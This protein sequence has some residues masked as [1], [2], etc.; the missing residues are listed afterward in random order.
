MG[1]MAARL[2]PP[3][4]HLI[5]HIGARFHAPWPHAP[6]RS[7]RASSAGSMTDEFVQNSVV[8]TWERTDTSRC[9]SNHR[10]RA[11]LQRMTAAAAGAT[12]YRLSRFLTASSCL[13]S[14]PQTPPVGPRNL[15]R[16][17]C[18][19]RPSVAPCDSL[20]QAGECQRSPAKL[21]DQR[22]GPHT[23]ASR[24]TRTTYMTTYSCVVRMQ[25][26]SELCKR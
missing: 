3:A 2:R 22:R 4:R 18:T 23:T 5:S 15:K 8:A 7:L 20:L 16:P 11:R 21:A 9:N 17:N 19:P 24:G 10:L 25:P 6:P 1:K 14:P 12:C 13:P 26:S